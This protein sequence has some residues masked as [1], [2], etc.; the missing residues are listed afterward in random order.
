[1]RH[2]KI[3]D[4]KYFDRH[5]HLKSSC[6]MFELTAF[7]FLLDLELL[8]LHHIP[9]SSSRTVGSRVLLFVVLA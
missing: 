4:S 9:K 2:S 5:S 6:D 8:S 1:M 3:S 7:L